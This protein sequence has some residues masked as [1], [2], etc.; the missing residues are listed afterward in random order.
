MIIVVGNSD[1]A[2]SHVT[3]THSAPKLNN[4]SGRLANTGSF[5][6]ALPQCSKMALEKDQ[7]DCTNI[8]AGVSYTAKPLVTDTHSAVESDSVRTRLFNEY[9]LLPEVLPSPR[10]TLQR[11]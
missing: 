6:L 7:V 8:V 9:L 1:A 10:K 2:E 3:D 11:S 5:C 4:I